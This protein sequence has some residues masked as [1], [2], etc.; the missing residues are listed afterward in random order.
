[1]NHLEHT[2]DLGPAELFPAARDAILG[3]ELQAGAGV[4]VRPSRRMRTGDRVRLWLNP[5][6]P[7][8]PRRLRGRDIVVPIGICEIVTVID[9]PDRAGFAY[10][11]LPGHL[12]TGEQTFVVSIGTDGRLGVSIDSDSEPGH[13]LLRLGAPAS[14][15][16]QRMMAARYAAGLKRALAGTA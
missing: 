14:V 2:L 1:M 16:A 11:T 8:P 13:P 9:E 5:L 6:W 7:L 15:A 10:R 12:E 3:W 4:I